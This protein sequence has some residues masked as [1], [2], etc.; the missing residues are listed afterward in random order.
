MTKVFEDNLEFF[1][2]WNAEFHQALV[3]FGGAGENIV[4]VDDDWDLEL[5]GQRLYGMGAKLYANAQVKSYW[6]QQANRLHVSTPQ[7]DPVAPE[8]HEFFMSTLRRATDANVTFFENRADLR[9]YHLVVFGVG[10]G[11]H[12]SA[13]AN[14]TNCKNITI[15]ES[16]IRHVHA[17]MN[18]FDWRQFKERF[19]PADGCNFNLLLHE[20]GALVGDIIRELI[21]HQNSAAFFDGLCMFQHY[22][23][24]MFQQ[25]AGA[26]TDPTNPL[27]FSPGFIHDELNMIHNSYFNL[28]K[29]TPRIFKSAKKTCNVPA[30]VIGSGPSLDNDL[31]AIKANHENAIIVS[32]GSSIAAMLDNGIIPD[33]HTEAENVVE[34]FEML[35]I[36]AERHDI[37]KIPLIASTTVHPD[38]PGL[39]DDVTFFYRQG[40]SSYPLFC[41]ADDAAIDLCTPTATNLG[42]G[43]AQAIGCNEIYLFGVDL[44]SR[45]AER[46]HAADTP[47]NRGDMEFNWHL[48]LSKEVPANFGGISY[49]HFSYLEAKL[50]F[51]HL[52]RYRSN[53]QR[54]FNCSDGLLID[55]FE[56]KH[57][58]T[59][60]F[61][62]DGTLKSEAIT[63]LRQNFPSY[64]GEN[65]KMAWNGAE[66]LAINNRLRTHLTA[67]VGNEKA[68]Y[69]STIE[70]LFHI[71]EHL[72]H[73]TFR[74]NHSD[75]M[76]TE[77]QIYRGTAENALAVA[78]YFLCRVGNDEERGVFAAIVREEIA[79]FLNKLFDK[80]DAFYNDLS[81]PDAAQPMTI[82]DER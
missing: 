79:K 9:A 25:I 51:E 29:Q 22:P 78:Y 19:D 4:A 53:G 14:L 44:G 46:H 55:G 27:E 69:N 10:L 37:S 77:M 20:D 75:G 40:I 16:D 56:P 74:E 76:T 17:S 58:N 80:V 48:E 59:I 63:R 21:R 68:D 30:F 34:N 13:L 11:E 45:S 52:P 71:A 28:S 31:E 82:F 47:Y 15:V 32:C 3:S 57:S 33:F 50:T 72:P 49:T 81:D 6:E 8:V 70:A 26:L 73:H 38:M 43:F 66:R 5:D 35:R 24:P 18:T 23:R 61:D 54:Y 42:S 2:E 67:Y 7:P 60:S 36:V 41:T 65:F 39:F 62:G 12:L 64:D 1:R